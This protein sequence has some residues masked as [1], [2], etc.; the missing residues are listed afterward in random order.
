MLKTRKCCHLKQKNYYTVPEKDNF[1]YS[2]SVMWQLFLVWPW[3]ELYSHSYKYV[4]VIF[5]SIPNFDEFYSED[6][7]NDGGKECIR[8][9]NEIINDFDEVRVAN[10]CN[11]M[12]FTVLKCKRIFDREVQKIRS[13]HEKLALFHFRFSSWYRDS[14]LDI[15][16]DLTR[17]IIR[18]RFDAN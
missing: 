8:F 1:I 9:L 5:A 4:T 15:A 11:R 6:Q 16:F 3:Q 18:N 7:I 14:H 10:S 17:V 13:Q 12:L 2:V